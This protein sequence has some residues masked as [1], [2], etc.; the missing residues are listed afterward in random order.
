MSKKLVPEAQAFELMATAIKDAKRRFDVQNAKVGMLEYPAE[1]RFALEALGNNKGLLRCD[2]ETL[3]N[4]IVHL[5][6][7]G[8]SLNPA[9]Q[10]AALIP[11]WNTKKG[12]F[13]CTASPMYRGLM[14]LATD[15][16]LITNITAELVFECEEDT[17][18]VDLGS[19]P[20]LKHKMKLFAPPAERVVN[21]LDS[22]KNKVIGGY[23]I[24]HLRDS[25]YPN[26]TVMDLS[27][28][29]T[30]AGA[31]EAFAPR[32]PDKNPS[33]PWVQWP[34]EMIKKAVIRRAS[35]QWPMSDNSKYAQLLEAIK[36]DNQAEANEQATEVRS[37]QV[38]ASMGEVITDEQVAILKDLCSTQELDLDRVYTNYAVNSLS[39]IKRKDFEE[40]EQKL[41]DRQRK[42]NAQQAAKPQSE[43]EDTDTGSVEDS[44]QEYA[45]GG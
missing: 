22:S 33:G 27:E 24:A 37:E 7:M 44:E 39:K 18:D 23:C 31:S 10:Q 8:L 32:K 6:A 38:E 16:G 36:I 21:L 45:E 35:K 13:D 26:I 43:G 34:G 20:Y 25:E 40:L 17:F 12:Q 3:T 29:V 9:A 41:L 28:I 15:T 4:S 2:P 19:K 1:A 42:Y 11:R 14:K 30:I 5:A